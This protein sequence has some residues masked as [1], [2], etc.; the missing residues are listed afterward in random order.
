MEYRYAVRKEI[1]HVVYACCD[2]SKKEEPI[3]SFKDR[4]E[5]IK[6]Q[7]GCQRKQE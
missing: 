3:A 6:Y 2:V 7:N 1:K 4:G 5:A